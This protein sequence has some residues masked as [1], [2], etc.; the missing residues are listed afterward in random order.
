[1]HVQEQTP[2]ETTPLDLDDHAEPQDIK[3][4]DA[5][6]RKIDA[7]QEAFAKQK[8]K[9]EV[10]W[11]SGG[12]VSGGSV[13][14]T[15]CSRRSM[16]PCWRP[17]HASTRP[18]RFCDTKREYSMRTRSL[19]EAARTVRGPEVRLPTSGSPG[20][21]REI[22]KGLC[23]VS[24]TTGGVPFEARCGKGSLRPGKEKAGNVQ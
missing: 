14:Q 9:S 12:T 22:S 21:R 23:F 13:K 3:C 20:F 2:R 4:Y 18:K 16:Q 5:L 17:R 7:A 24:K 6:N 10:P 15:V 11:Y 19:R 1:M 8:A